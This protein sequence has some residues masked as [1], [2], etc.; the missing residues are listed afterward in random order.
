M[1]IWIKPNKLAKLQITVPDIINAV[2]TQNNVNPAGQIGGE[3]VPPGQ[4]FTYAVR[5]QGRLIS[6]EEF[7]RIVSCPIEW[8]SRS[9]E[10]RRANQV[11]CA[12][13]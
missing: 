8:V 3:P 11:G 2:Q 13:L 12:G 4:E 7:G 10:G 1:R 5:A 9:P 6:E